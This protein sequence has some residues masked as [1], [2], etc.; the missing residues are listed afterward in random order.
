MCEE[1]SLKDP[2][3]Q[4]NYKTEKAEKSF[5]KVKRQNEATGSFCIYIVY[6]YMYTYDS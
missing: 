4:N 5:G 1:D 3:W 2:A 6:M